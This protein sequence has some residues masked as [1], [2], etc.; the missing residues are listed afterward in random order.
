MLSAQISFCICVFT[1]SIFILP[2][3]SMLF[4]PQNMALQQGVLKYIL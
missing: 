3:I 1:E 2:F 4:P